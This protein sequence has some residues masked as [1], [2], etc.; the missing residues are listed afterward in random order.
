M[1]L[2]KILKVLDVEIRP[3]SMVPFVLWRMCA[4]VR[5]ASADNIFVKCAMLRVFSDSQNHKESLYVEG[6]QKQACP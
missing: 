5:K 6:Q 3:R 4:L 1:M 2:F